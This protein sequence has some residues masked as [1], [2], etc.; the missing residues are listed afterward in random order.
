MFYPVAQP[1]NWTPAWD[2]LNYTF[3]IVRDLI[4]WP[5]RENVSKIRLSSAQLRQPRSVEDQK[6][7]EM[8][9]YAGYIS[10][11]VLEKKK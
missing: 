3:E 7:K 1:R 4:G 10:R 11:A 9:E 5:L 2:A 6:R 8:H